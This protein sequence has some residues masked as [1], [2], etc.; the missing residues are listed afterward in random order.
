[1]EEENTVETLQVSLTFTLNELLADASYKE[2]LI[3]DVVELVDKQLSKRI[4]EGR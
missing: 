1:M 2:R 4:V 3:Q